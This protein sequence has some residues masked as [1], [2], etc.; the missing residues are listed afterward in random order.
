MFKWDCLIRIN[1]KYCNS[2]KLIHKYLK[3]SIN[4]VILVSIIKRI[5]YYSYRP[6]DH[7]FNSKQNNSNRQNNNTP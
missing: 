7:K 2:S 3:G 1:I 5:L 4:S 6:K